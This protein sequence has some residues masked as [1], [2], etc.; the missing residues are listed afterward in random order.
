M[1]NNHSTLDS[2]VE[3]KRPPAHGRQPPGGP[4]VTVAHETR[5]DTH[6]IA[7]P[8]CNP[9]RVD[10]DLQYHMVI[11]TDRIPP[12]EAAELLADGARRCFQGANMKQL[13]TSRT[14]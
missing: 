14:R 5:S 7:R 11:N 10:D 2:A 1:T 12:P 13:N 8:R 4:A 6:E 3:R 9:T